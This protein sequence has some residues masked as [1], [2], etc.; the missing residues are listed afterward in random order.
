M[1]KTVAL[2]FVVFCILC[3][4]MPIVAHAGEHPDL[5]T[6]PLWTV[7]PFAGILLAIALCSLNSSTYSPTGNP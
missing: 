2:Y 6:L 7:I 5:G 4:S 3:L 1:K